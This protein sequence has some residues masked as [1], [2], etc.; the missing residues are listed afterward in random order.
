MDP[1][2]SSHNPGIIKIKNDKSIISH[3]NNGNA[4][5][6]E[7]ELIISSNCKHISKTKIGNNPR[8]ECYA[9]PK[10]TL[11]ILGYCY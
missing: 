11:A 1:W 5:R 6:I 2:L 4:I 3:A 8:V 9:I 10:N 7:F